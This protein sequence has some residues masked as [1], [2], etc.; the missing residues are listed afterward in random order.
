MINEIGVIYEVRIDAE[1]DGDWS[2]L[3]RRRLR[4]GFQDIKRLA[5]QEARALVAL[6]QS[7]AR[8]RIKATY[9]EPS[10]SE[11][12]SPADPEGTSEEPPCQPGQPEPSSSPASS[13]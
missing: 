1:F 10:S 3:E 5:Q 2:E 12:P 13:S 8:K 7:Q 6:V 11:P 4:E 9:A